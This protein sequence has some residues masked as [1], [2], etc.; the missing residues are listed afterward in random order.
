MPEEGV[1]LTPTDSLLST[2]EIKQLVN[3]FV[4]HGVTKLRFTGGEPT[5]RKDL[6][7]L[8]SHAGSLRSR[9]LKQVCLTTNGLVL[10]RKLPALI[11]AGLTH[12][13]ISLDTLDE[14]KF[15]LMTRRNGGKQV[16]QAIMDAVQAVQPLTPE[17]ADQPGLRSVKINCV[18]MRGLNDSE[19]LDFVELTRDHNLEV[20]F[21]E[22]MPFD[23]NRWSDKKFYSYAD[24]LSLIRS[25]YPSFHR[26]AI[27]LNETAKTWAVE[28]H[29]GRVGFITSMS[30]HFC[31]TC[32]RLRITADGNLKV[33]LFG[34]QEVSLRD[35]M[36]G[37]MKEED[38]SLLIGAAVSKKK[39]Q[40][41]GMNQLA[42][43][44]NRPMITIGG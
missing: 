23:G 26:Q 38:L 29:R 18:I 12:V 8:V 40:H 1:D 21:I 39:A 30:D 33:C 25:R 24:M 10:S 28:G 19:I 6:L 5:V 15:T 11:Q 41:A 36:R 31:S 43:Q 44:K 27:E 16:R 2:P 22:Y 13:N 3:H 14:H 17:N 9:G 4:S 34:P 20:R 32:N 42:Q 37:G 7:D 35:A